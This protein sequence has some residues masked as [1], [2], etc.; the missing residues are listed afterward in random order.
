MTK[1]A[2]D[3]L[4]VMGIHCF[5]LELDLDPSVPL[6]ARDETGLVARA[7]ED[8][9]LLGADGG[10]ADR[11]V[12]EKLEQFVVGKIMHV[13]RRLGRRCHDNR[14]AHG[15]SLE[16]ERRPGDDRCHREAAYRDT[17]PAFAAQDSAA[18]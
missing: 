18:G 3:P 14:L 13:H 4:W 12:W 11:R 7:R 6:Q 1:A 10:Q 8:E 2:I 17:P 15:E 9:P 16:R 5:D